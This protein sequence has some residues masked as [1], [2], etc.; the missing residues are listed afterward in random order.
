MK[1]GL[2]FFLGML[3]GAFLTIVLLYGVYLHN[4][5]EEAL[6][7]FEEPGKVME[8]SAYKV[9]QVVDDEYAL[10]RGY[11]EKSGLALGLTVLLKSNEGQSYYDDEIVRAPKG[12]E[13]RQIGLFDYEANSGEDKTVPV[14]KVIAKQ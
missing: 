14:V 1:K 9:I 8:E 7:I 10:A 2:V 5:A 3:A 12:A 13:F 11:D 4:N 6:R